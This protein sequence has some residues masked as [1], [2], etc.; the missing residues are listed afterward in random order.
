MTDDVINVPVGLTTDGLI[1]RRYLARIL[2]S[3]VMVLL[4]GVLVLAVE[5]ISTGSRL[6]TE[7]RTQTQVLP[8]AGLVLIA[9]VAYG[10]LL[11]SSR[12]QGTVGKRLVGLRVYNSQGAR[13]TMTQAAA[14]A[15]V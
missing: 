1:G 10:A 3:I 9:W 7:V 2:D 4:L 12:W 6:R 13:V 5:V 11:E 14:R 8:V 15:F